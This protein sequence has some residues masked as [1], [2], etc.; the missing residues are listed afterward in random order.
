MLG[1]LVV[2]RRYASRATRGTSLVVVVVMMVMVMRGVVAR[3]IS[4]AW[5]H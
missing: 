4:A 1:V 2:S 5:L 3:G